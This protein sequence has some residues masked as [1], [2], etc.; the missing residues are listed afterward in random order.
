MKSAIAAT[1]ELDDAKWRTSTMG[2]RSYALTDNR[3]QE[4]AAKNRRDRED[5]AHAIRDE[6]EKRRRDTRKQEALT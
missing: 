1:Q 6:P 2:V 4:A 5:M 3:M